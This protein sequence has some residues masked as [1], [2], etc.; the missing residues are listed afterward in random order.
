MAALRDDTV[1]RITA[2]RPS[3]YT[4]ICIV[5]CGKGPR[6]IRGGGLPENALEF[7]IT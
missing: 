3:L 1:G 5:I 7:L 4:G 2:A 6:S